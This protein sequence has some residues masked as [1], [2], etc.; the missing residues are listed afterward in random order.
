MISEIFSTFN[1]TLNLKKYKYSQ[2]EIIIS[3]CNKVIYLTLDFDNKEELK[4]NIYKIE[5]LVDELSKL[6][7]VL[8]E[9]E[10]LFLDIIKKQKDHEFK[11]ISESDTE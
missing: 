7:K 6:K 5:T 4:N 9:N 8:V 1:F 11:I 3:D 2:G 10:S